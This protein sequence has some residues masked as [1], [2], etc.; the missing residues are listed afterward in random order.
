MQKAEKFCQAKS[1]AAIVLDTTMLHQK[2]KPTTYAEC[3]K[4]NLFER[5][6]AANDTAWCKG[7]GLAAVQI[8]VYLRAAWYILPDGKEHTLIN[9]A[10]LFGQGKIRC[11]EGCLSIPNTWI[12]TERWNNIT[13]TSENELG[14]QIHH[15][16]KDFEALVVQHEIDHMDGILMF[17]RQAGSAKKV[18]RNDPCP[19]NSGKKYKRCC[20]DKV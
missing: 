13:F 6:K 4:L 2:S 9:P 10:I 11:K 12:Q 5:L 1:I 8:G 20:V 16:V 15:T 14:M 19:C 7:A 18:G 3:R 17:A